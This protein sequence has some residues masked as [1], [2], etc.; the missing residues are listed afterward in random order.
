VQ[1][2]TNDGKF[3]YHQRIVET[4]DQ[5]MFSGRSEMAI[6]SERKTIRFSFFCLMLFRGIY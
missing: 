3:M 5:N 4:P 2:F 1:N 6:I